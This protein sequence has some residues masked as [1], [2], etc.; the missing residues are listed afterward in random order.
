MI[1]QVDVGNT[2]AKWRLIEGG[3]IFARGAGS[4]SDERLFE[5]ISS[6]QQSST[7]EVRVASVAGE[8]GLASLLARLSAEFGCI[9]RV[10]QAI[11]EQAGLRLAYRDPG[12]IGVDRWL[13]MLAAWKRYRA[14]FVVVDAGSALTVDFVD[15]QGVHGGG[16]ILP[17][18][19]ML[20]NA[21][22]QGTAQVRF[23]VE[24]G[25]PVEPGNSTAT[26]VSHGRNWLW[27][28]VI[29]RLERDC[30]QQA[31]GRT[32]VTGGD[33]GRLLALGLQAEHWPD[34]VLDG[35]ND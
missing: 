22:L 2:R 12:R 18:W 20:E 1:L 4:L 34:I 9:P 17:G 33:A 24:E 15:A 21:L 14:A 5:A 7:S 27:S 16:Y 23:D 35:M 30:R 19:R 10:Y 11:D 32:I 28:A 8:A 3:A 29:E 13:A 25:E 26:C 31:I 6:Q